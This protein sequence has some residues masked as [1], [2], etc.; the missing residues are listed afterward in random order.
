MLCGVGKSR[1][2]HPQTLT[3]GI[4]ISL[5]QTSKIWVYESL[6]CKEEALWQKKKC[7][8]SLSWSDL[9][10]KCWSAMTCS[11]RAV[12]SWNSTL[13]WGLV[14]SKT[15]RKGQRDGTGRETDLRVPSLYNLANAEM[16][17][18]CTFFPHEA[19]DLSSECYLLMHS[20]ESTGVEGN[21]FLSFA[22]CC[23]DMH[24][25]QCLCQHFW[26]LGKSQTCVGR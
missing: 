11:W 6:P 3:S 17:S 5:L 4:C 18:T 21:S 2:P 22:D 19:H 24:I 15:Q 8:T 9:L 7:F 23:K 12:Q 13:E 1:S 14:A 10:S 25:C 20:G 26:Q 16:R